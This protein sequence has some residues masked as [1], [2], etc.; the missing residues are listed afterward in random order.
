MSQFMKPGL[1]ARS[2][3]YIIC[4]VLAILC[5]F[6]WLIQY[7]DTV[8]AKAVLG[9]LN[10]PKPVVAYKTGKLTRLLKQNGDSTRAGELLGCME[11]TADWQQVLRLSMSVDSLIQALSANDLTKI[12]S[13]MPVSFV[14]LGELQGDYQSFTQAYIPF[15]EFVLGDYV[16]RKKALLYND[17]TFISRSRKT[18]EQQSRL[19]QED[20]RL[21]EINLDNNKALLKDT[22]ISEQEYRALTSQHISKRMS[23]AQMLTSYINSD[24]Q[25]NDKQKEM[26]ELDN[27][28]E[29]NQ[30]AFRQA[31][32]KLKSSIDDWKREYLL[33]A[34]VPGR[35]TYASFLQE[36]QFIQAGKTIMFIDPGDSRYHLEALIPQENL[37]KVAPGQK[38]ILRFNAWQWQ[39]YGLV[40]GKVTYISNIASDSGYLTRIELPDGLQTNKGNR[41]SPREGLVADAEIV[42]KNMRLSERLYYDIIKQIKRN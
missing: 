7:P 29:Q 3:T 8:N 32:Y 1:I 17:L 14:N 19:Q 2:G 37:G 10:A 42:T 9:G 5:L 12:K 11:T 25:S 35:V 30:V 20:L 33:V 40:Y 39:E 6:F 4:I 23:K 31:V 27:N 24:A 16:R 22:V 26:L 15:H 36:N 28:I 41:L 18:L 34:P 38:V 21:S 13:L